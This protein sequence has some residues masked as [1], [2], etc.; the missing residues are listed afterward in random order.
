MSVCLIQESTTLSRLSLGAQL[1]HNVEVM[2]DVLA[3]VQ[4][5]R[6]GELLDV[7]DVLQ[8]RLG[9]TQESERAARGGV[10]PPYSPA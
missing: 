6:P 5:K 3:V 1:V 4:V 8:L 10:T 2:V 9:E 7:H